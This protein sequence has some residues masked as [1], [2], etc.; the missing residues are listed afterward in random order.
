MKGQTLLHRVL[1]CKKKKEKG[2]Y[3]QCIPFCVYNIHLCLTEHEY[4]H[5][6]F[7]LL[8]FFNIIFHLVYYSPGSFVSFI[9]VERYSHIMEGWMISREKEKR[10]KF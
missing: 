5:L 4:Y 9:Q 10:P 2:V 7:L 8:F 6:I 3:L 1:H